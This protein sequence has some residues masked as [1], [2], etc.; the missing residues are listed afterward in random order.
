MR[1]IIILVMMKNLAAIYN[2]R[3]SWEHE[4][5]VSWT[6]VMSAFRCSIFIYRFNF[7]F[8]NGSNIK[9]FAFKLLQILSPKVPD[10]LV[11]LHGQARSAQVC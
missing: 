2:V 7:R 6:D 9:F 5:F 11:Y 8:I 3:W 1:T 10:I 4:E